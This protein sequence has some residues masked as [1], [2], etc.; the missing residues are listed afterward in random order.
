MSLRGITKGGQPPNAVSG[1]TRYKDVYDML[2]SLKIGEWVCFTL[3]TTDEKQMKKEINDIRHACQR[4]F[5]QAA[6]KKLFQMTSR[7]VKK[8]DKDTF[9][10]EM[11]VQKA[12]LPG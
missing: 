4:Y 1:S 5:Y 9:V 7:V 10:S 11:W 2:F 3:E 6:H 8:S 12:P